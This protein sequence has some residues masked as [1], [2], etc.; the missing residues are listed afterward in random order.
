MKLGKL[1][2]IKTQTFALQKTL[3]REWKDIFV[4]DVFASGGKVFV[5]HHISGKELTFRIYKKLSRFIKKK[6][7][8]PIKI[9][10]DIWT[11]SLSKK[12]YWRQ[13]SRW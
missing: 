3:L 11:D 8:K 6:M 9:G 7:N 5:N 12:I 10:Q 4:G 13:I 1:D 2:F